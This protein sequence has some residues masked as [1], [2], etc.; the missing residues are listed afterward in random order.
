MAEGA[1]EGEAADYKLASKFATSFAY[2][3]FSASQGKPRNVTRL[4]GVKRHTAPRHTKQHTGALSD[5]VN[6]EMLLVEE[7]GLDGRRLDE[8]DPPGPPSSPA[9]PIWPPTPSN[10]PSAPPPSLPP[11]PPIPPGGSYPDYPP[12]P[13]I[14]DQIQLPALLLDLTLAGD[15]VDYGPATLLGMQQV[16]AGLAGVPTD[17]VSAQVQPGSVRVEFNI[18]FLEA[19]PEQ[20]EAHLQ[21]ATAVLDG[22]DSAQFGIALSTATSPVLVEK[23]D[24]VLRV[25]KYVFYPAPPAPPPTIP[26]PGRPP[27]LPYLPHLPPMA[28]GATM[29]RGFYFGFG[30]P[31]GQDAIK[32]SEM[33]HPTA[34]TLSADYIPYLQFAILN[35]L[36]LTVNGS[37]LEYDSEQVRIVL[38]DSSINPYNSP[39]A[40]RPGKSI[41]G[42]LRVSADPLT[43]IRVGRGL[44][45]L[46]RNA[47]HASKVL[48]FP[49]GLVLPVE[50]VRGHHNSGDRCT[51]GKCHSSSE[52]SACGESSHVCSPSSRPAYNRSPLPASPPV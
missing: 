16:V 41:V 22:M 49:I 3:R 24:P 20:A 15:V 51:C 18:T 12:P 46:F 26:P 19:S 30:L 48:N 21:Q 31:K 43:A 5:G 13:A 7:M 37:W 11:A 9:P 4:S 2:S 32:L 27:Y 42:Y 40:A 36:G 45:A 6:F 23:K 17:A 10:P 50:T 35:A 28:P 1:I 52:A 38:T 34:L 44:V 29:K 33:A 39:I 14:P 8:C 47:S 25:A